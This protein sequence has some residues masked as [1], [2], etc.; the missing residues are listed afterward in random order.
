MFVRAEGNRDAVM[1]TSKKASVASCWLR[2]AD[3]VMV[4]LRSLSARCCPSGNSL[5]P[6][7]T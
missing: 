7:Y 4:F 6:P 1:V 5:R 3:Y 2:L